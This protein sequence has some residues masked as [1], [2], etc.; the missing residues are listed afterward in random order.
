MHIFENKRKILVTIWEKTR[1]W[2][3]IFQTSCFVLPFCSLLF[4]VKLWGE[5]LLHS[6]RLS[7]EQ[8]TYQVYESQSS[9]Q[10]RARFTRGA[11]SGR[12]GR[13][14]GA[15]ESSHWAACPP[16]ASQPFP[17]WGNDALLAVRSTCIDPPPTHPAARKTT[18]STPEQPKIVLMISLQWKW[19]LDQRTA[20][21]CPS[22]AP[23]CKDGASRFA[24]AHMI[25]HHKSSPHL[26][27]FKSDTHRTKQIQLL[28]RLMHQRAWNIFCS[29]RS[30]TRYAEGFVCHA[31]CCLVWFPLFM[32]ILHTTSYIMTV[33]HAHQRTSTRTLKGIHTCTVAQTNVVSLS[34]HNCFQRHH[35]RTHH[36]NF[37][38]HWSASLQHHWSCLVPVGLVI[39]HGWLRWSPSSQAASASPAIGSN[40]RTLKPPITA[41]F[42]RAFLTRVP[43]YCCHVTFMAPAIPF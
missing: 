16:L 29:P 1:P 20:Q 27:P 13:G 3:W 21:A 26:P 7:R 2:A 23:R 25:C 32:I 40:F 31:V 9:R 18:K 41:R 33:V 11:C 10:L 34:L 5:L 37:I 36:T 17:R 12:V 42:I 15:A 14:A 39:D 35:P 24:A 4:F 8:E 43:G 38:F 19:H 28:I 30:L 6:S 22:F